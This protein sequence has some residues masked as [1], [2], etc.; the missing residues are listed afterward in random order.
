MQAEKVL[1]RLNQRDKLTAE[2]PVTV[3]EESPASADHDDQ[4]DHHNRRHHGR[5]VDVLW[6]LEDKT[7]SED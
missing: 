5:D 3:E 6:K 1:I 7:G 2:E 4:A